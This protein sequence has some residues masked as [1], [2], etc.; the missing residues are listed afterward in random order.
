MKINHCHIAVSLPENIGGGG[1]TGVR[2]KKKV[3]GKT[4]EY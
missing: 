1:V 2:R 3:Y 4:S